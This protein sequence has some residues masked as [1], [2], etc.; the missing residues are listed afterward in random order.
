M[1]SK[2]TPSLVAYALTVFLSFL[3][4]GNCFILL[5]CIA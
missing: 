3:L 1:K 5:S 4:A 2:V